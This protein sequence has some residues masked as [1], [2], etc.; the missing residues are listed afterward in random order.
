VSRTIAYDRD[1]G[2]IG[3]GTLVR[4]AEGA[5][6]SAVGKVGFVRQ[7]TYKSDEQCMVHI[8]GHQNAVSTRYVEIVRMGDFESEV[9]RILYDAGARMS[10]ESME[11]V[12]AR[13][14]AAFEADAFGDYEEDGE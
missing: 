10:A 5:A 11:G 3:I 6:P 14:R 4:I 12:V 8:S 2:P 13:L 9:F 1:G 7:V